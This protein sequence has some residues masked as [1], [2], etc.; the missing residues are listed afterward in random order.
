MISN[1]R[2]LKPL[3]LVQNLL[4]RR[5]CDTVIFVNLCKKRG[6]QSSLPTDTVVNEGSSR[7][8]TVTSN[9]KHDY[10]VFFSE[11]FVRVLTPRIID[12]R[13]MLK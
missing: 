8:C 3:V 11:I 9:S 4:S 5:F 2:R 1:R 10:K 6:F 13:I 7:L 12:G